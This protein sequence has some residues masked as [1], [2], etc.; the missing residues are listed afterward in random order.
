MFIVCGLL[1]KKTMYGS[2]AQ[3]F[4]SKCFC[5]QLLHALRQTSCNSECTLRPQRCSEAAGLPFISGVLYF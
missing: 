2:L 3:I 1:E 4:F 5:L